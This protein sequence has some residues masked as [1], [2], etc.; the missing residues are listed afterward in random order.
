VAGRAI[1]TGARLAVA[2]D[3]AV[4]P[5]LAA[6]ITSIAVAGTRDLHNTLSIEV[7][8]AASSSTSLPSLVPYP[9]CCEVPIAPEHNVMVLDLQS[10]T[11]QL[12]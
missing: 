1:A 10:E 12:P 2:P 3:V 9:P 4:Q 8:R 6:T 11:I 5:D 7:A